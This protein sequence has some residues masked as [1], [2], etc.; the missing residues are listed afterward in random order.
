M[1]GFRCGIF[2]FGFFSVFLFLGQEFSSG[3]S[4]KGKKDP[5]LVKGVREKMG[6]YCFPCPR[7]EGMLP[8]LLINTVVSVALLMNTLRSLFLLIGGAGE[9]SSNSEEDSST[10]Q[11]IWRARRV[12]ISRYG[13]LCRNRCSSSSNSNARTE[14]NDDDAAAS[15]TT[16]CGWPL[17][18]CCV[19]LSKFEAH[20]EVSELSCKHFF[21]KGCLEKWFSNHH[22]TCPLCRSVM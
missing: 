14:D 1:F 18:E 16:T 5:I 17:T 19:C 10:S 21:H 20:E 15:V 13:S 4:V 7:V 12:S 6:I 8:L 3:P 22:S 2:S 11:E 9:S